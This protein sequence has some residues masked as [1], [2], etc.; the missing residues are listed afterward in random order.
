MCV[1]LTCVVS[2]AVMPHEGGATRCLLTGLLGSSLSRALSR[3]GSKSSSS[4]SWEKNVFP[5]EGST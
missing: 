2:F 3:P 5:G 1:S 4:N